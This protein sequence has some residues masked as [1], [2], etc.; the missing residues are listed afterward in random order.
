[1]DAYY[2]LGIVLHLMHL[3]Y[4][5]RRYIIIVALLCGAFS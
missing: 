4:E 1:M 2:E 5:N 3:V